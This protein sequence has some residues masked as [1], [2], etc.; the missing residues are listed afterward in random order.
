M[1]ACRPALRQPQRRAGA[2]R[3]RRE[4]LHRSRRRRR[5][6][7]SGAGAPRTSR[8]CSAR[9]CGSTRAPTAAAVLGPGRQPVRRRPRGARRDLLLRPAQP[10]ALLLR[11][12][13]RRR[14]R[15]ATSARTSRRRSTSSRAG[16]GPGANFGWSAF[17]GDDRFNEDQELPGAIPP[18][19]RRHP[20]GR[21]LLDHR[22]RR[23]PRPRSA[24][25]LRPLPLGR[26]LPRRS[27]RASRPSRAGPPTDDRAA[28]PRRR[29]ASPASARTTRGNVYA[30]S[31][32]GPR[33]PARPG[34]L[35]ATGESTTSRPDAARARRARRLARRARLHRRVALLGGGGGGRRRPGR[36]RRRGGVS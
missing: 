21:Q 2:L 27:C 4:A 14:S 22:R 17:E 34:R 29:A 33:L 5:C 20:R 7:R 16:E 10:V 31:L 13:D 8:T 6:R 23:R 30:V 15:S 36:R 24:T 25:P 18:G 19:A 32:V 28:R 1:L 11:S 3:A 9:S 12:R 35:S 26:L